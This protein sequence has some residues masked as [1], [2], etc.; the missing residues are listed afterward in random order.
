MPEL[1]QN[2]TECMPKATEAKHLRVLF[3]TNMIPPYHKPLFDC[4]SKQFGAFRILLSTPMERNRAWKVEWDGLDVR[5]QK[6]FTFNRRWRHPSGFNE[7]LYIHVP[8]DTMAQIREF[9][10]D[11]VVSW[12]M[13]V[14]TMFAAAYRRT[15]R[16]SKLMVW[17]EFA[18]STEY[19]RGPVRQKIRKLLHR[20]VDGFLVT[21]RSGARYLRALGVP[22]RK[23][24]QIAYTTDVERF[25]AFPARREPESA[26]RLLYVGQLIERK[27]LVPFLQE[28]AK[29][30]S[31]HPNRQAEF[32]LAGDGP[33]RGE[34]EQMPVP[35]NLILTFLGNVDYA[36]L[37]RVYQQAGI[38]VFPTWAD[39]WGV[40]VN[41]AMAAG[42][43]V[44]GSLRGQAISEL[45]TD[46]QT[47]WTFHSDVPGSMAAALA[48]CLD[49]PAA[50]L[51][52]MRQHSRLA[53]LRLTPASVCQVITDAI[54][55]CS[56]AQPR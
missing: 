1:L 24:S 5:V 7:A 20:H 22:D 25:A 35:R 21:G 42:L 17:A 18:E 33:L 30:A 37:P 54:V 14:R 11:V 55:S 28:L 12:E 34:L 3:L 32:V 46:A 26:L 31:H 49:T 6:T 52:I 50:T 10:A 47:G 19:G 29:W 43:P 39:T 40:V 38:F 2:A 8:V 53:A 23:L 15:H 27:G 41:E 16:R 56:Q 13:G 36:S 45:V 48:R 9:D 44:L 51:D 4:L